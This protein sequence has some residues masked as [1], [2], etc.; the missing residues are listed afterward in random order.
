VLN[1]LHYVFFP[2]PSSSQPRICFQSFEFAYSGHFIPRESYVTFC[3]W[4]LLMFSRF[5]WIV[6]CIS[7]LFIFIDGWYSVEWIYHTVYPQVDKT[8]GVS[9]FWLVWIMFYEHWLP[10]WP[11]GEESAY[12]CQR[13]QRHGFNLWIRKIPLEEE[14][15]TISS[16]LTGKIT[17]IEKP[18]GLQFLGLQRHTAVLWTFVYR[19]LCGTGFHSFGYI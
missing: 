16:I 8:L 1:S 14:V 4:L 18:G 9:T 5:I 17:W 13:H 12:Q 6:A 19:F 15:A 10:R 2:F 11:S 3:D 7:T